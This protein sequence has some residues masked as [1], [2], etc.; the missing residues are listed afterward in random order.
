[1][2]GIAKGAEIGVM[3][4]HNDQPAA[5]GEQTMEVFHGAQHARDV[6]DYMGGANFGK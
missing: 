3:R 4:R 5:W 2:R 1:M 6:F